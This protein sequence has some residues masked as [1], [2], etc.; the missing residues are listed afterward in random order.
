[1]GQIHSVE[2]PALAAGAHFDIGISINLETCPGGPIPFD[3]YILDVLYNSWSNVCETNLNDNV[4]HWEN[5]LVKYTDALYGTFTIGGN[6]PDYNDFASA[7]SDLNNRGISGQVIFNVRPGFYNEQISF[8]PVSGSKPSKK[9]IFQT[10]PNKS[11]TAE[12]SF[13]THEGNYTLRFDGASNITFKNMIISTPGYSNFQGTYGR[14]IEFKDGADMI[15]IEGC[16]ITGVDDETQIDDDIA[17]IYCGNSFCSN[18]L[19]KDN[20]I[21]NG[22]WAFY[23]IGLTS[24]DDELK[25]ITIQNNELLNFSYT[26]ILFEKMKSP[27]ILENLIYYSSSNVVQSFGIN[28]KDVNWGFE[29]SKNQIHLEPNLNVNIGISLSRCEG[30]F[31]HTALVANNFISATSTGNYIY[32]ISTMDSKYTD[33]LYNS[34]HLTGD[35]FQDN[36]CIS[37]QCS[38]VDIAF[39]NR[40]INNILSNQAGGYVLIYGHEAVVRNYVNEMDYND[41]Y[42][43]GSN[44]VL[45]DGTVQITDLTSWT[46]QSGFDSHSISGDP[47]FI[48]ASDLHVQSTGLNEAG[49]PESSVTDDIDG[50]QR[51]QTLPDIGADEFSPPPPDYD[52]FVNDIITPETGYDLS[53]QEVIQIGIYNVGTNDVSNFPVSYQ[54]NGGPEITETVTETVTSFGVTWYTFT[55]TANLSDIGTYIISASTDLALD[56]N[57][58]NDSFSKTIQ[59]L[60]PY[61]CLPLY[62]TGCSSGDRIED[63]HLGSFYHN[64]TGCSTNGYG[65]FT[66]MTVYLTQ[67][68]SYPVDV[69]MGFDDQYVS[70]W[71][72]YNDDLTFSEDEQLVEDLYCASGN[73]S[74]GTII[75]IPN[76]ALPG[77]HKMRV[78]SAWD[79]HPVL[80]CKNYGYGE[81]HDYSVEIVTGG[82][83]WVYSGDYNID[84][85]GSPI[86]ISSHVEGGTP[87]YSYIWS[88]EET[89]EY[90]TVYPEDSTSYKVFITDQQGYVA[91][92]TV[93]VYVN[94]KPAASAE[95]SGITCEGGVFQLFGSGNAFGMMK[96]YCDTGCDPPTGYCSS[97]AL[98]SDNTII[99]KVVLNTINN[100]TTGVCATYSDFTGQNTTLLKNRSYD[101]EV[102]LGTCGI[103]TNKTAKVYLDWNRDGDFDDML[104]DASE[105]WSTDTTTSYLLSIWVPE[106]SVLGSTR[107]RIVAVENMPSWL[108]SACGNYNYGETEDYTVIIAD[109]ATNEI[110]S[111]E[112]NGP[113][114]FSST[115][116]NPI[117]TS[118]AIAD[119]GYYDL[120]VTD[121]NLCTNIDSVY[122]WIQE[123][124]I[125]EAGPDITI[126]EYEIFQPTPVVENEMGILWLTNGTG[127]FDNNKIK[128]PYYYPSNDDIQ[129]GSVVLKLMV[130]SDFPCEDFITD[131]LTL[132]FQQMPYANVPFSDIIC[133]FEDYQVHDVTADNYNS[134]LWT[135]TGSGTFNNDG[136]LNPIYYPSQ[137]DID[138]GVIDLKLILTGIAPCTV[139]TTYLTL[140]IL[141]APYAN[142]GNDT[143]ICSNG[144]LSLY[145]AIA[146]NYDSLQW[147][148]TGTG[149]FSNQYIENP[150]YF[151]SPED[152]A[153]G[154]VGIM[155]TAFP[156]EPCSDS[157]SSSFILSI[158]EE[159]YSFAGDFGTICSNDEFPLFEATAS[160]HTSL[161]WETTGTGSFS[162]PFALNPIYYPGVNENGTIFLSLTA[163][164]QSPCGN[165][166]SQLW[167]DVMPAPDAYAGEDA[168]IMEGEFYTLIEATASDYMMTEWSTD[169]LG[170]FD[171]PYAINAIYYPGSAQTGDFVLTLTAY[172]MWPCD[173]VTSSM[174]LSVL[175]GY[176]L[177]IKV[178]LE[179]PF[180][181]TDMNTDLNSILPHGQPYGGSPW[182]YDGGDTTTLIP[183]PNIVDWILV[184]L[185][186]AMDAS[187]ATSMTTIA[188][189]AAFLKNGGQIVGMDGSSLLHF[190]ETFYE[191]LFVVLKH[192]NHVGIISAS[193]MSEVDGIYTY[194]FSNSDLKVLGG[195]TGYK[196]LT[197]E[198]WG[199]AGGD[200]DANGKIE[201]A[202]KNNWEL[203][204][205]TKGYRIN[206]AMRLDFFFQEDKNEIWI[207]NSD[208]ESQVPE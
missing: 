191:T 39:N 177:N 31:W 178:F 129:N 187:S 65:D 208:K 137:S 25:D 125:A 179:G 52:V 50:E 171:D 45:Y 134:L 47:L 189:Q 17:L 44:L 102:T 104:E 192:R 156:N 89:T 16:R 124:A 95:G 30:D 157:T 92:D 7:V 88:T 96:V 94:A 69:T 13:A 180:N 51:N 149:E 169:G 79:T 55:T 153:A 148:T 24:G 118:V 160:G 167:L 22:S 72:D 121:G 82:G 162:D 183:D 35:V 6:S 110:I 181:G 5:P 199:L 146:E 40:V 140:N 90:I 120:T 97:N 2:I 158:I 154:T 164:G 10:E 75:D 145:N 113:N 123:A 91:T 159:A 147:Y 173:S 60:D 87:P 161:Y 59:N 70:L 182:Y 201:N 71:I 139:D 136:I 184:E 80:P 101:M 48:S 198:K 8:G 141:K 116:Q 67:G 155:M 131:S 150:E 205:G 175:G 204:A 207:N 20:K 193:P 185:R 188:Q 170:Y 166:T 174:T 197:P 4:F 119:T 68:L 14:V 195:D 151:P 100:N 27:V 11:D 163:Y 86:L 34:I 28:M 54:I 109:S 135:T 152:V 21:E 15:T 176:N 200:G 128:S 64:G 74:Y 105:L 73:I 114:D 107:M 78:R 112:W 108:I 111:Y 98:Y 57:N 3:T 32:G 84:C 203:N 46:T 63:F 186:D 1:M 126:C 103:E 143:T 81:T 62:T 202:D 37:L 66:Y 132:Y 58:T 93:K 85:P 144:S 53:D 49:T 56:E 23:M 133:E 18:I 194:D 83:M 42:T 106:E 130:W 61:D 190:E 36:Y 38:D 196:Q 77:R 12:I 9:I 43:T 168:T 142:A 122:V 127:N 29:I 117:L 206:M 138:A 115:D 76:S 26:G 41:L 33:F 99:E 19:F 172:G 165:A